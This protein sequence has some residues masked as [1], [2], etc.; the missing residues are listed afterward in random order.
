MFKQDF[1]T[2]HK[3]RQLAV[4]GIVKKTNNRRASK[5]LVELSIGVIGIIG[6]MLA[7]IASEHSGKVVDTSSISSTSVVYRLT[8]DLTNKVAGLTE[9]SPLATK[10]NLVNILF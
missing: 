10:V 7:L 1:L 4:N 9:V 8:D 3:D 5:M 2:N 6:V